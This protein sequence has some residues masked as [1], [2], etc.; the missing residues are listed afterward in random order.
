MSLPLRTVIELYDNHALL[1][2]HLQEFYA[3]ITALY[4]AGPKARL[5]TLFIRTDEIEA[6][7]EDEGHARGS[8]AIGS[9]LLTTFLFD[10]NKWPSVHLPP[11]VPDKDAERLSTVY[12]YDHIDPNWTLGEDRQVR[13]LVQKFINTKGDAVF[14]GKGDVQLPNNLSFKLMVSEDRE[15]QKKRDAW[16]GAQLKK[17]I[18]AGR[19]DK[20]KTGTP[21]RV[22]RG[23]RVELPW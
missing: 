12:V 18:D 20:P 9:L 19:A 3:D 2:S 16:V 4:H 14:R 15:L 8:M 22:F 23:S 10:P 6:D 11:S 1:Y 13:D 17:A 21:D 7:W 5:T